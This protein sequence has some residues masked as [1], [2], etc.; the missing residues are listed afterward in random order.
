MRVLITGATGFIGRRLAARLAAAGHTVTGLS[1]NPERAAAGVPAVTRFFPWQSGDVPPQPALAGVD[2]VIHLA[3][4]SVDGRWSDDK[5]RRIASSRV[6]G[7]RSL[8]R[9]LA[10]GNP[11]PAF[12]SASAVGYYGDRGDETLT[13]ASG[14]G[15]GF[16]AGVVQDWE[17]EALGAERAGCRVALMRF[18]IVLG[19]EG[20]ALAKMLPLFRLGLGG[21]LGNGRQWWPWVHVDDVV[22]ALG[23]A[24]VDPWSGIFNVTAPQ[25]VRQEDFAKALAQAL[26]RPALAP[27]VPAFALRLVQGEFAD[28]I[29]F[30]KR[31]LP[32]H[33]LEAGFEFS[34]PAI[35]DALNQLVGPEAR[36]AQ[37]STHA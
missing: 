15:G 4:E 25:P 27:P 35:G 23:A 33:L 12:I 36:H 37:L 20:G 31:V 28:E 29:L 5:K 32:R 19:R 6:D 30:S 13:E 10:A 11:A 14:P 16:L 8:V 22:S 34:Y 1:R 18:G 2:A 7:T 3:G 9:S 21:K 17:R 26:H 24:A